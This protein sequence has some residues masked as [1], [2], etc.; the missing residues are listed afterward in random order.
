VFA[1]LDLGLA[2]VYI[3]LTGF[4][5]SARG[6]FETGTTIMGVAIGLAGVGIAVRRPWG[7]WLSLAGCAVVLLGALLL[8]VALS[9]SAAFLWGTFGA[10]GTGAA[11][12]SLIMMALIVEV[13]VLVPAFQ[14][15][16]LLSARG[17]A[18][19]GRPAKP[20]AAAPVEA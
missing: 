16:Y 8:L 7:Y 9:T 5:R 11:I 17:R 14:L 12:M 13:Y 3:A 20:G 18:T 2:V 19:A 10:L 15:V 6:D 4:V 1:A